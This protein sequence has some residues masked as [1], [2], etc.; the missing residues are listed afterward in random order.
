MSHYLVAL[1]FVGEKL[2]KADDRADDEGDFANCESL[3][4]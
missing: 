2:L 1:R 3:E 4:G